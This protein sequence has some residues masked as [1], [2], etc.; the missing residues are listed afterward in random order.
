MGNSINDGDPAS[1]S[2]GQDSTGIPVAPVQDNEPAINPAWNPLLEQLPSSLH[3]MVT[4]HLKQWDQNYQQGLQKVHSEYEPWKEFKDHN[5][6]PNMV[7]Q[8]WQA[9]QNLEN[10]PQ[11]FVN[12]VIQHYGLQQVLA[13]QG[14]QQPANNVG[15]EELG[16]FSFSQTP[17]YQQMSEELQRTT[18]MTE[19]MAQLLLAQHQQRQE[20]EADTQLDTDLASAKGKLGDMYDE[21]YLLQYMSSTGGNIDQAIETYQQHVNEILNKSRNPS[22]GAPI[23]MGSGGGTPAVNA[24]DKF[25]TPKDRR[26]YIAQYLANAAANGGQKCLL[27]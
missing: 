22:A 20:A 24:Q 16:E 10:D 5:L 23:I 19:Q 26:A 9:M 1:L 13:E 4:P 25:A 15:E 3:G 21:Q 27:L 7:Y 6:D 12:A 11:G 17:E 14:Q 18:G 8:S 2:Q